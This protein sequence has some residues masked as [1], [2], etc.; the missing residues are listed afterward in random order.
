MEFN[1][2][3]IST[4]LNTKIFGKRI[5]F[6]KSIKS[7]MDYAKKIAERDEPEGTVIIADY[8][9]HGRGRFGR[10]WKSEP[11]KNILMSIILRPTIPLE[12][13]SILAFL[14]S[15]SVAEAI[16]KNTNLKITTKWPNDLLINNRKFCGIL[17]EASITADKGD[18]VILG[19]GINVNQSE[20]PKEIQ[21]YATSLYLS[22]G[23]VYDRAELTKD[24]LR[25]IEVDYEKLNKDR[26]FKSVI[27]RWKKRCTM[28]SQKITVIQSG[29]TITGKA[30][31]IDETGFL[32]LEDET[33][34]IIKLSS[35]D[36]TVVK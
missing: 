23:K 4:N 27:E 32:I 11:G 1:E 7:T 10:I 9:S 29:K 24:I 36:V 25:Q 16:E 31:D 15:V 21:D 34:K 6:F 2:K 26:D 13:F 8:Q 33:S 30:I 14:F 35:G 20:F 12:K 28:L 22:T 17:M 18:F 3:S 5:F 19:I